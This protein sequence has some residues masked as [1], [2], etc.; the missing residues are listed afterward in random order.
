MIPMLNVWGLDLLQRNLPTWRSPHGCTPVTDRLNRENDKIRRN[1]G[2]KWKSASI[3][4]RRGLWFSSMWLRIN[5]HVVR[6]EGK[7]H[8]NRETK[9]AIFKYMIQDNEKKQKVTITGR[10]GL[11]EAEGSS[12]VWTARW[13]QSSDPKTA[14]GSPGGGGAGVS[15]NPASGGGW[16]GWCKSFTPGHRKVF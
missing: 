16:V 7:S 6:K 3:T 12:G 10:R 4:G 2:Q 1:E 15:G 13:R 9:V 14:P 8:H 11:C 5:M